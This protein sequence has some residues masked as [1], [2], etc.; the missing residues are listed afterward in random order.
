MELKAINIDEQLG[1]KDHSQPPC[2]GFVC[3]YGGKTLFEFTP[4]QGST[5][6]GGIVEAIETNQYAILDWEPNNGNT[7]IDI[8]NKVL[9]FCIAKYGDGCGGNFMATYP[10]DNYLDAFKSAA[11]MTKEWMK[12]A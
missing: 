4:E 5:A 2:I 6:Y 7:Y 3:T 12:D 1:E 8:A 9:T 10:D 11:R